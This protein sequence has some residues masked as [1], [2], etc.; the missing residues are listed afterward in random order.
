M[1]VNGFGLFYAGNVIDA[2]RIGNDG[3][4]PYE[5]EYDNERLSSVFGEAKALAELGEKYG[6]DT[7]WMAEHHFQ[8]EGFEVIPN[9]PLLSL[10]LAQFTSK[11]RFGCGFNVLP[12]WHPIRLA[13]DYAT[14]DL[15]TGGRL[16]LG[17]ARGYNERELV[18]MN[19]AMAHLDADGRRD[20]FEEQVELL[21]TALSRDKWAFRGEHYAL[22]PAGSEYFSQ[23]LEQLTLVPRPA[24]KPD[25]WQPS[26]SASPRGIE[27]MARNGIKGMV[28]GMPDA[29][30]RKFATLFQEANERVGRPLAR[31]ENLTLAVRVY[32]ADTEAE[33]R[34]RLRPIF[35]EHAKFSAP[36]GTFPYTAELVESARAGGQVVP[37][38]TRLTTFEEVLDSGAW[39]AGTAEQLVERIEQYDQ[40]FPGLEE[41]LVQLHLPISLSESRDQVVRFGEQVM[42]RFAR[43]A[44]SA[45]V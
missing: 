8:T 21:I 13:E 44:V 11:I 19:P 5:R 37:E 42:P 22:P 10:W 34:R 41:I 38:G 18:S 26:T 43:R 39:F 15:L 40:E 36:Q 29:F 7:M 3:P 33:A 45:H 17:V 25:I 30:T 31:G 4:M 27:F 12:T 23:P 32:I 6:Y 35:E 1:M 20:L 16:M 28:G 9:I 2:D 24:Q 14:V